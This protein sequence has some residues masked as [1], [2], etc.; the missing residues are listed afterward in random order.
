MF[1]DPHFWQNCDPTLLQLDSNEVKDSDEE[2]DLF[3]DCAAEVVHSE[4]S[5]KAEKKLL[6]SAYR[7]YYYMCSY[8]YGQAIT[9]S[10]CY[11]YLFQYC[12]VL[13]VCK[14]APFRA[15]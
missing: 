2:S 10:A 12:L 15:F 1:T 5:S 3:S 8:H 11:G 13:C 6:R 7:I 4:Q 14:C 9:F